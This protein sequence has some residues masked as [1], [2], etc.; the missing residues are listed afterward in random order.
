MTPVYRALGLNAGCVLPGSSATERKAAYAADA[1][2]GVANEFAYDYL[3][4]HLSWE[5]SELVQR[6]QHCAIVDEADLI[7]LDDARSIP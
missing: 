5:V 2:Y 7:M 6:G 4:D 3:R 1:T